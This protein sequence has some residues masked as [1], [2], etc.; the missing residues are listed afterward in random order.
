VAARCCEPRMGIGT[1][2]WCKGVRSMESRWG[3]GW[4][5]EVGAAVGSC[6]DSRAG[7]ARVGGTTGPTTAGWWRRDSGHERCRMVGAKHTPI[8]LPPACLLAPCLPA[9]LPARLCLYTR[10]PSRPSQRETLACKLVNFACTSRTR[11]FHGVRIQRPSSVVPFRSP[12]PPSVVPPSSLSYS[13]SKGI[14]HSSPGHL[15][16]SPFLPQFLP[17]GANSRHSASTFLFRS[18]FCLRRDEDTRD[19]TRVNRTTALLASNERAPSAYQALTICQARPRRL[20]VVYII[21]L[22]Y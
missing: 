22:V 1:R 20:T 3:R 19:E 12:S 7:H 5:D 8:C 13:R 21:F 11:K 15:A 9:C 6:I 18:P 14:S 16:R 17:H 10:H 2:E 4:L